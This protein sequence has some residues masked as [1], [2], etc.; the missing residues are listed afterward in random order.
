M[1]AADSVLQLVYASDRRISG[2]TTV[3]A[4]DRSVPDILRGI[5]IGFPNAEI[6]YIDAASFER[7][8]FGVD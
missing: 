4:F 8:G 1:V 5:E 3:D 6:D 2:L 7:L